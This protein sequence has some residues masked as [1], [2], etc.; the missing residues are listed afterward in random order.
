MSRKRE[1]IQPHS[2]DRRFIRRD[3]QGQWEEVE[4]VGRSLTRDGRRRSKTKGARGQGDRGD[5]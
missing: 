4:D 1:L 3:E 5:R 2:G